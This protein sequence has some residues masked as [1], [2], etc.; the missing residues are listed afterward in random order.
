MT[1]QGSNLL[2]HLPLLCCRTETSWLVYGQLR[3]SPVPAHT[4]DLPQGGGGCL[5][6]GALRGPRG[7]CL[8]H[9]F[10]VALQ[11][12]VE[13]RLLAVALW[14]DERR[15]RVPLQLND[16]HLRTVKAIP[17]GDLQQ[18]GVAA[19]VRLEPG[20]QHLEQLVDEVLLLRGSTL[21]FSTAKQ[22]GIWRGGIGGVLT[23]SQKSAMRM[24]RSL[25]SPSLA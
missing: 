10:P 22:Q 19:R 14:A 21:S 3:P 25:V 12:L 20:C 17:V 24:A 18:T 16:R 7:C 4:Q 2:G 15:Q 8:L 23:V 11:E 5:D 9:V 13:Q 6:R 1:T